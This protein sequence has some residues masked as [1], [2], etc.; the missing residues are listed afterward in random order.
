MTVILRKFSEEDI[1]NKI[2][3]MND[4]RNN[5]FL[6][7]DFP[8]K[9]EKTHIWYE[10][11]KDREDRYDAV[12]EVDKKPVGL[13]GLLSMDR[14][15][16]KAEYYISMGEPEFK[17]RGISTEA[18]RLLLEHAFSDLG[19]KK[20][21]LFTESENTAAQGLFRKVGFQLEGCFK[22]DIF[23]HGKMI[24]RYA[25][26]IT[27]DQYYASVG[28]T[29]IMKM[30]EINE[31]QIYIKRDDLIPYSFG[32]N[33]ARKAKFFLEKLMPK[34]IIMWLPMEAENQIIAA[35]YQIW[36]LKEGFPAASLHPLV[37]LGHLLTIR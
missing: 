37:P 26:G 1:E 20:I 6:H 31:N 33:K 18:S 11:I 15:N 2:R 29:P 9:Y 7:Y 5:Q 12:I 14:K 22:N 8:L 17:G 24:E 27:R 3:W 30:D 13:I 36:Q 4:S 19:L 16:R 35:L 10:G 34:D 23:S 25:F 32:G 28:M 21:Y